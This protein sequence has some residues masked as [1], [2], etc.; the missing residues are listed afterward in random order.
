MNVVSLCLLKS[1]CLKVMVV[2]PFR[3]ELVV[4]G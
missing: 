1:V 4:L 2:H 3:Y